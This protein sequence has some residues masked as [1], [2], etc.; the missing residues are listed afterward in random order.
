MTCVAELN[1][2]GRDPIE[3]FGTLI[4]DKTVGLFPLSEF[5]GRVE[6]AGGG[7]IDTKA[8]GPPEE[9]QYALPPGVDT[10]EIGQTAALQRQRKL[11]AADGVN[12]LLGARYDFPDPSSDA[13]Y[14]AAFPEA[15]PEPQR[16]R[17]VL[18]VPRV[19]PPSEILL[20]EAVIR[21]VLPLLPKYGAAAVVPTEHGGYSE[22]VA[23]GAEYTRRTLG[24]PKPVYGQVA[25]L[26]R[27][28]VLEHVIRSLGLATADVLALVPDA[29]A[30][31]IE[32][33]RASGYSTPNFVS[34]ERVASFDREQAR[35]AKLALEKAEARRVASTPV[36]RDLRLEG[37]VEIIKDP[38]EA[39]TFEEARESY[40]FKAG[41]A[42]LLPT[43]KPTFWIVGGVPFP[44]T[45]ILAPGITLRSTG[46]A[47]LRP[48]ELAGARLLPGGVL[49]QA[50]REKRREVA[51]AWQA[52][53]VADLAGDPRSAEGRFAL[54]Q[55]RELA[56]KLVKSR[57]DHPRFYEDALFGLAI[58]FAPRVSIPN[59]ITVIKQ[60]AAAGRG[61]DASIVERR[62][63]ESLPVPGVWHF[64]ECVRDMTP[65]EA[66]DMQRLANPNIFQTTLDAVLA[67]AKHVTSSQLYRELFKARITSSETPSPDVRGR[68]SEHLER[69]GWEQRDLR[70]DGHRQRTWTV[71]RDGSRNPRPPNVAEVL[72]NANAAENEAA[73]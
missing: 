4:A 33:V 61:I 53:S 44:S 20:P 52:R 67:G 49:D 70:I 19:M 62:V 40:E 31:E 6:F 24:T 66:K 23:E 11:T 68:V 10:A 72:A 9:V 22:L 73:Q 25:E 48:A 14:W 12:I 55:M 37:L 39:D 2:D 59:A 16:P 56:A 58:A 26:L 8:P 64:G 1:L 21:V 45:M 36:P 51:K 65:A 27:R 50:W 35:I 32:D 5:A 57:A 28:D 69:Q 38:A 7:W 15:M 41:F 60:A 17:Y 71:T 54:Q 63:V 18:G 30:E 13:N 47:M 29:T 3:L 43:D 42:E 46:S 34:N